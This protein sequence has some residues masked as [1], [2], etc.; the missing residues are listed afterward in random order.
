M[1]LQEKLLRL[2]RKECKESNVKLYLGKGKSIQYSKGILVNGYFSPDDEYEDDSP[3]L[4]CAIGKPRW[5]L[6]LVHEL[7]HLRQWREDCKEWRDYAKLKGNIIDEAISGKNVNRKIL[8]K[9]ITATILL[10]RDC[11]QRS[12]ETLKSLGY[13]QKKLDEYV[14]KANAYTIFYVYMTDHRKWYVIGREPYNVENVW[15]RFPKT[16]DVDIDAI[17][18][19]LGHLYQ[20]CVKV[21]D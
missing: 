7:N 4:C 11:E 19:K 10:E 14:Q 5:E 21:S 20:N 17:Y 9:N 2:V 1:N 16:F 6:T 12:Y 8:Q 3:K 15:R 18:D 13:P